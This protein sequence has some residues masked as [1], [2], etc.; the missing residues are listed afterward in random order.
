MFDN[1]INEDGLIAHGVSACAGCGLELIIRNVF[2]VLGSDVTAII[3]PGCSALFCGYNNE[4]GVKFPVFQGNLENSAAYATGISRGYRKQ[5]ND[6]TTVVCFCGDGGTIDIGLQSLSGMMER[7]EDVLY[8]C[9]D[10]EAYMNTGIQASS[11]SPYGAWTTTT[12]G[13]KPDQKKNLLGIAIAH[14]IPYCASASVANIRD[15]RKKVEKAKA[16]H[17]P[18]LIHVHAPCPT[19]WRS[20]PSK[21]IEICRNA[22]ESCAWVLYEYEYGNLRVNYKP[23]NKKPITE[24][25]KFQ[26]RFKNMTPE[27]I[28]TLQK[29]VDQNYELLLKK[30]EIYV[31]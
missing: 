8:I 5:G 12:P 20:D 28:E 26:G 13:G 19:G 18:R 31:R 25:F 9:Y 3:P 2:D 21:S 10:N 17:G 15:L 23:K 27:E 11:S 14:D 4:T 24:Y 30:E 29:S 7:G 6:H 16:I 22:V 1:R